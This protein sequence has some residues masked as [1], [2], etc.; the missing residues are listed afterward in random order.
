VLV[1]VTAVVPAA[2]RPEGENPTLLL[3]QHI[4]IVK[5]GEEL[6][7]LRREKQELEEELQFRNK[8][9]RDYEVQ[10]AGLQ[11]LLSEEREK[12]SFS[13]KA[14]NDTQQIDVGSLL[15]TCEKL[16]LN[17]VL[18]Y[19]ELPK[20]EA[21][22]ESLL[23]SVTDT[24]NTIQ[25]LEGDN[26]KP[27]SSEIST[28]LE[29]KG[30]NFE[31]SFLSEYKE[32]SDCSM[33]SSKVENKTVTP[34]E[35]LQEVEKLKSQLDKK[36]KKSVKLKQ[37][38]Q[39]KAEMLEKMQKQ[40]DQK[41][42]NIEEERAAVLLETKYKEEE[43]SELKKLLVFERERVMQSLRQDT[44]KQ[45]MLDLEDRLEELLADRKRLFEEIMSL[46][47]TVDMKDDTINK[48][49]FRA[50]R[51]E[52]QINA[53]GTRY[54]HAQQ[55]IASEVNALT[56]KVRKPIKGGGGDIWNFQKNNQTI[57]NVEAP[58]QNQVKATSAKLQKLRKSQAGGIETFVS[59]LFGGLL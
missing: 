51:L 53:Q 2:P 38:L 41:V 27:H 9:L 4:E 15:R 6:E 30:N 32:I 56:V 47:K 59:N 46:R 3:K 58:V 35:L 42:R 16:K 1:T 7:V 14:L 37:D 48:L 50:E 44:P 26:N 55:S 17:L 11:A 33:D 19:N 20:G 31:E 45:R 39:D 34:A 22:V 54:V 8:D 28:I 49:T 25:L 40:L 24:L 57:I 21:W 23:K 36:N 29:D 52:R 13:E 5:L 18:A 43:I 10:V 12:S